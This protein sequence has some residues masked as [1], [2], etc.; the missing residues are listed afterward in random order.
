MRAYVPLLTTN[1]KNLSHPFMMVFLIK[2]YFF[3]IIDKKHDQL[4][5]MLA[6]YNF[7]GYKDVLC[8][9][10]RKYYFKKYYIYA[11]LMTLIVIPGIISFG[12]SLFVVGILPSFVAVPIVWT[13]YIRRKAK[14]DELPQYLSQ[15]LLPIFI[16]FA[17]YMLVLLIL[18]GVSG[19]SF[20]TMND[21]TV[22]LLIFLTLPYI[23]ATIVLSFFSSLWF[24]AIMHCIVIVLILIPTLIICRKKIAFDRR[25]CVGLA[26]VLCLVGTM[27]FQFHA[28]SQRFLGRRSREVLVIDDEVSLRQYRPFTNDNYLVEMPWEPTIIFTENFPRLDG[29]TA[30]YPVYAAIAQAL[31]VGLDEVTVREYVSV[32]QTDVAYQ[33]LING[34]ID[35]F[36]GAQPSSEQIAAAQARGIEFTMTPIAREA[37]VFFVHYD[38]PVDSLTITQIQ[39]IYQ[40][41]ISNWQQVGG[42]NERILPFQRPENSGSQTIMLAAVMR[43]RPIAY[44]LREERMVGM[45]GIVVGVAQYRN[46]SSAIGYSFRYFVTGMRPHEDIKLLAIEGIAPTPENIRNNTYPFTVNVYAVTAGT[47]NENTHL[48]IEWILS[49]QGQAFIELCGIVPITG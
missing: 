48:L 35:V 43:D 34:E 27:V 26:C 5:P 19:Y 24:F 36:F 2:D 28:R 13:L 46:Y 11:T 32:S 14:N 7:E 40:R 16:S 21:E 20:V 12:A 45:G 33:R 49:E 39:D 23:G 41:Q 47:D 30:A 6:T 37:F 31:F 10:L 44:P 38:N 15:I 22:R 4:V 3:G 18:F 29:A 42:R 9:V 25:I 8:M 1:Y 17:Y